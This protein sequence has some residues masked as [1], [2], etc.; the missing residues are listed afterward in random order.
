MELSGLNAEPLRMDLVFQGVLFA[1]GVAEFS[2]QKYNN[3]ILFEKSI[4]EFLVS[5]LHLETE[6]T[7]LFLVGYKNF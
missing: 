3:G 5:Y 1:L 6:K 4:L 2:S 7:A